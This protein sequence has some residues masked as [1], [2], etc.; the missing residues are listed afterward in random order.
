MLFPLLNINLNYLK[1]NP[2]KNSTF[3]HSSLASFQ[4]LR[5]IRQHHPV[6]SYLEYNRSKLRKDAD[7]IMFQWK[8][9]R[10]YSIQ[11]GLGSSRRL[12]MSPFAR[13]SLYCKVFYGQTFAYAFRGGQP[14]NA[15]HILYCFLSEKLDVAHRALVC[16]AH[17]TT[18][19]RP[20]WE[21]SSWLGFSQYFF[22]FCSCQDLEHLYAR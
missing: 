15:S 22:F 8:K 13:L 12:A 11:K 16:C 7:G 5:S 1:L 2:M 3:S 18:K 19:L 6:L 20:S 4:V 10:S 21:I 9:S 17:C 14:E